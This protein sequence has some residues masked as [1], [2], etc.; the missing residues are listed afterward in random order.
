M[1]AGV[2]FSNEKVVVA[3]KPNEIDFEN[4]SEQLEKKLQQ[5]RGEEASLMPIY[6]VER[7][8]CGVCLFA[9]DKNVA[10]EIASQVREGEF[11]MAYYAVVVGAPKEP[12]GIYSACV[13]RD[14]QTGLINHIP[15]LNEGAQS[16]SL[17]YQVLETVDKI[18][19]V[20]I[21]S[22]E[23]CQE[24]IRFAF[25][26]MGCPVFGD[27]DYGGDSLAKN[28]FLALSLVDLRFRQE[29]GSEDMLSFRAVPDG[30]PW[31]YF[32]LD[33]WFKI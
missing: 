26:D 28:T 9:L 27:K 6:S 8:S 22:V 11:E 32:N 15:E 5:K 7:S 33:K 12:R 30:K 25:F 17:N 4:F 23:F 13:S 3:Y 18:S 24:F 29:E 16:F 19:L 14:K 1:K 20:K 10:E 2:L 31:S 21:S